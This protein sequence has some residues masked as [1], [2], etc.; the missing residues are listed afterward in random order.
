MISRLTGMVFCLVFTGYGLLAQDIQLDFWAEEELFNARTFPTLIAIGG[1]L[2]S[3]AFVLFPPTLPEPV[4]RVIGDKPDWRAACLLLL[5]LLVYGFLL[6]P[7]G[8]LVS[9]SLMLMAGF[10]TLGERRWLLLLAVGAG[11]PLAFY[12]LMSALGIHLE[13]GLPGLT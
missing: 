11:L 6:E 8:F 12:L 2:V 9:T 3:L 5:V 10:V 13:A 7:L 4:S 1:T